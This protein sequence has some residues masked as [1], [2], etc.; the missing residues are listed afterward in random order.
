MAAERRF[1]DALQSLAGA[2]KELPSPSMIIGGVAVIA[3][4]V[5]R[6]TIDIDVT[7]LGRTSEIDS[8][9]SIFARHGIA[10][11]MADARAFALH[12]QILLLRHEKSGVAID[13]S[14]A[15]LPFEEQALDQAVEIDFDGLIVRTARPE[16]LVIYK[17]AAWRERDRS[18]IERLL[19]LHLNE[20]DI[21]RVRALVREIGEALDDP[22][23]LP[24]FDAIVSRARSDRFDP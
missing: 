12:R 5:P 15:W 18:D 24:A 2:L 10:P 3:A 23:R 21:E 8:V 11:R 19:V 17:A 1:Q 22:D 9:I 4:G 16:D 13:V 20:I 6:Q 7:V 14:F